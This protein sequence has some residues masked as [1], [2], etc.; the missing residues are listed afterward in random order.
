VRSWR[1]ASES[2]WAKSGGQMDL[3]RYLG[4]VG[5]DVG[6]ADLLAA[7]AFGRGLLES[8]PGGAIARLHGLRPQRPA[9]GCDGHAEICRRSG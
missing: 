5:L 6:V 4:T 3:G 9:G 1:S 8:T 2:S 7:R